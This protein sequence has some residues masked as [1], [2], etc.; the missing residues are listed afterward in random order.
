[1]NLK[2]KCYLYCNARLSAIGLSAK[3]SQ[4]DFVFEAT[5]QIFLWQDD[6]VQQDHFGWQCDGEPKNRNRGIQLSLF[7]EQW[8]IIHF[9]ERLVGVWITGCAFNS[10]PATN[11]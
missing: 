6:R 9:G 5:F 3:Y 2:M 11:P 7:V 8:G 4:Y 10:G 1:M